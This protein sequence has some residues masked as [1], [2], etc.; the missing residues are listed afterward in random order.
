MY[1]IS[2]EKENNM[3]NKLRT[4]VQNNG[5]L[6][7]RQILLGE[8]IVINPNMTNGCI[9]MDNDN[10]YYT[11]SSSWQ[12]VERHQGPYLRGPGVVKL[13]YNTNLRITGLDQVVYVDMVCFSLLDDIKKGD[14]NPPFNFNA[15]GTV[16][17]VL[18]DTR[19]PSV[20]LL[21]SALEPE[22][23]QIPIS[24]DLKNTFK[25]EIV[26][27]YDMKDGYF[28]PKKTLDDFNEVQL[29]FK[30]YLVDN[31]GCTLAELV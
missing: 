29:K 12:D 21:N 4:L 30:Q 5:W 14:L 22:E 7:I 10:I 17:E 24:N 26:E 28:L 15:P 18:R 3:T 16:Y 23:Y 19:K 13:N 6:T 9:A 31:L 1:R 11:V 8:A 2:T 27:A 25:G 20:R